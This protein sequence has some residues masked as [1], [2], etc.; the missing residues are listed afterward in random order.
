MAMKPWACSKK[1]HQSADNDPRPLSPW[2]K[3][4]SHSRLTLR[5]LLMLVLLVPVTGACAGAD[6]R[7]QLAATAREGDAESQYALGLWCLTREEDCAE[8]WL[9][10]AAGQAHEQALVALA[11]AYAHGA[12]PIERDEREARYWLQVAE[13]LGVDG[14]GRLLA[15]PDLIERLSGRVLSRHL[16]AADV[17][18]TPQEPPKSPAPSDQDQ[19]SADV[20]PGNPAD[21]DTRRE[22]PPSRPSKPEAAASNPP[23][24]PE[25]TRDHGGPS[26]G[27]DTHRPP[28]D[29]QYV[30]QV[31]G[32]SHEDRLRAFVDKHGL[33]ATGTVLESR[34]Q[35]GPWFVLI[36]GPY[37]TRAH[38]EQ[39]AA[40]LEGRTGLT[41]WVRASQ[42]VIEAYGRP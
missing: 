19:V 37:D 27:E 21:P 30:V 24:A 2:P 40:R 16:Q 1:P 8:H 39:A 13:A 38:A 15:A 18:E 34:R 7:E 36:Q 26:T 28:L 5:V 23:P 14:A 17:P 11:M 25:P 33:A 4:L 31:M 12:G 6:A 35:G 32:T 9:R 41:P 20:P 22:E 10:Q 3:T 42:S 29:G